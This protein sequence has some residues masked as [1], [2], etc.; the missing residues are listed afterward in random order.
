MMDPVVTAWSLRL[1]LSF[2]CAAP[3]PAELR[4]QEVGPEWLEGLGWHEKEGGFRRLPPRARKAVRPA[5]WNLA[6][7]SAG[8]ALR[9]RSDATEIHVRY[10]LSSANLA[11]NHMPATGVSGLDLYGAGTDGR[12]HWVATTRPSRQEMAGRLVGGLDGKSRE[13]LLYLPLYNGVT[14]LA[15]GVPAGAKLALLPPRKKGALVFYGTSITQGG[16]ASRPGL[17]Y[18]AILGRTLGRPVINLG[19]SGNG[20]MESAVG[21]FLIELEPAAY[22]I[23]CLPNMTAPKVKE[24]TEPLVRQLRATRPGIPIVLVEGRIRPGSSFIVGAPQSQQ[25]KNRA[26]RSAYERL[27]AAGIQGLHYVPAG[28]LLGTDGEATVDGSH[29]TDLGMMRMAAALAPHLRRILP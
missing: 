2:L 9:F 10:R 29:P 18:P 16:C 8:L 11:M 15:L 17:A 4:W 21:K 23:D 28:S 13:Y 3:A 27:C 24:R 20:R 12:W 5:V 22:V 25:D 7:H 26:L 14:T 6:G 19:F 1:V